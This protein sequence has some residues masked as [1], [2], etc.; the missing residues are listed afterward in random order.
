[1]REESTLVMKTSMVN[2]AAFLSAFEPS[3]RRERTCSISHGG[4][5]QR[6]LRRG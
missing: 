4:R 5:N 3:Y 6:N 2:T 1:M